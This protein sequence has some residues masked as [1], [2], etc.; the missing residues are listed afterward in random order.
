MRWNDCKGS[1]KAFLSLGAT[2]Q[3]AYQLQRLGLRKHAG[4]LDWFISASVPDLTRLIGNRFKGF[5]EQRQ[6][7]PLGA[8]ADCFILK[9]LAYNVESYHDFPLTLT[10]HRL[11]DAYPGFKEKINRRVKR[12][13]VY[14][15]S[16]PICF[17]RTQT[18]R[19]DALLLRKALDSVTTGQYRL[20]IVNHHSDNTPY[21]VYEDWGL[22]RVSLV[23]VP[24]GTD[25][26]GSD[27]AWNAI[28]KGFKLK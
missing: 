28:M 12:F 27:E 19:R 8:T 10:V 20:L 11:W 22:E 25:W 17:V 21:A 1:Y 7:Q 18:T 16:S 24:G 14:A 15:Q 2:C 4:P 13:L 23:T 5:M 26:R 6:L 9:D 3:T